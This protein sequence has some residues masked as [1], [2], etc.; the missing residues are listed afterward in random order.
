MSTRERLTLAAAL[1]VAL[2]SSA[3]V[4]VYDGL[5][6][7]PRALGAVV[8]VAL[9][10]LV[11]RRA[12]VPAALQ[13]LAAAA[14]LFE[15]VSLVFARSTMTLGVV[16]GGRTVASLQ[17]LLEVGL[18]DISRFAPPV[19]S[20][21]GLA[22]IA[23]LGVG[24][25]AIVVDVV[26]VVLGR[27]ALA[28]LPLLVLFAVPSAVHPRGLGW[29]PFTLGAAGWLSLLLVEGSD[30]VG[31]WGT[32]LET[33]HPDRPAGY[34][35]PSLGR[36]GRRIGAAALGVAVVVPALIPGL[37][38][39]LLG[40]GDGAGT[41]GSRTTT[42]Y[43]PITRLRADLRLPQPRLVLT[44]TTKDSAPDY[45]RLTTL[46]RFDDAGWSASRLSGS[47]KTD[48]V[49]R[50]LKPP[51]G[52]T[53]LTKTVTDRIT[54]KTL[55]AQ[56]LP[57]PM[58]P[59]AVDVSGPWLY[60]RRSETIFGIRVSTKKMKRST[61]T[62]SAER[63]VP[64]PAALAHPA[65]ARV[66]P[67]EVREYAV[68]PDVASSVRQQTLSITAR[69][70]TPYGKVAALQAWFSDPAQKF[71]Y[72]TSSEVPGID[73][74]SALADFLEGRKGFC[75]QYA[76]AMAAMIRVAGVPARVA[77]GF[78]PGTRQRDG[79]YAVTTNDAHAWPEAWF[80]GAGW[81]RFE[82]T[83]RSDGQ[84]V[85]PGYALPAAGSAA[86]GADDPSAPD[87]SAA[88]DDPAPGTT[89]QDGQDRLDPDSGLA[90]PTDQD[91]NGAGRS[92]L[93]SLW[94][95][96]ALGIVLLALL[97]W[98]VHGIRLR[99]RWAAP[100][101]LV[102]WQQV[103][104][105]ARDVGHVWRPADSPR[106]AAAHLAATR[107]LSGP[108]SSALDRVARAAEQA[109]YA[110]TPE[111]QLGSLRSDAAVV[112]AALLAAA[113]RRARWRARLLP[114]ST[115]HWAASR[116]GTFVADALDR[117]DEAWSAVRRRLGLGRTHAA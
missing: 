99:R 74:P 7:L 83:P 80:E 17:K 14:V 8:C 53:A 103:R 67:Q 39:R 5:L 37:D 89:T 102:A 12:S 70:T 23:V 31:R 62:V 52:R 43:N 2:G 81:I 57:T 68:P 35:D 47:P 29:L 112:R 44:Y 49:G 46:D 92:V 106:A 19:P 78:T 77:V 101:P 95:A 20:T 94:A 73:S 82:P 69:E 76:S 66:L 84:T 59:R 115:L 93:L 9:A 113:G 64:D 30:R 114:T 11:T 98:A 60:D 21:T 25:V 65:A 15:Y 24:A 48:G 42:T 61:Y 28:G 117:F 34:E 63:V 51:L 38:A 3:L 27:A 41:G 71:Q 116:S 50:G 36:V 4:P 86:G 107:G 72:S 54:I 96:G 32:P 100:G 88:P 58:T 33:S 45:L 6:W 1:A 110:R 109:R 18:T 22:L 90:L 105:D 16:P 91:G 40:G 87:P 26:A 97:P 104:D 10:G 56:W 75:E 85:I 13:P 55:D 79:S 108:G 111:T